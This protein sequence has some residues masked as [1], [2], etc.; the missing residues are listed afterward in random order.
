[1][2]VKN[3]KGEAIVLNE[4]EQK[5]AD[6]NQGIVNAL[7]YEIDITTLTALSKKVIEQKFFEIKPSD[8][9][10]VL[11][12]NGAWSSQIT[13]FTSFE[14]S[15]DFE[16]GNIN[17]GA[18]ESRLASAD[19]GIDSITVKIK[20]WA[21]TIGWSL[22][23]LQMAS[24]SGNWDLIT[25]KE[26]ARKRNWDL[27]IQKI[28]FLG[29]VQD[30]NVKGLL[31]QADVT[32]NLTLITKKISSMSEAEISTFIVGL[33]EAYRANCNRT[34]YPTHFVI[35]ESDF[36]GLGAPSSSTYPIKTKLSLLEDALKVAVGKNVQILPCAYG[37]T[38][39]NSAYINKTRYA[40]YNFDEDSGRL[41]IPV[42]YTATLANSVNNFM[43]QNVGY[44][45][46]TGFKAFRPKEFLYFDF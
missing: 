1:M 15:N 24:K 11:V 3:S 8:Y 13:T 17:T 34:A 22:I 29:S 42:D 40:L 32:S 21:K 41:E 16:A 9:M 23:D 18:S 20:N 39:Y 2:I 45:Q 26:K 46:Y 4:R 44:G 30:A 12:G 35:P 19:T 25:S 6:Y 38:A 31:T 27:G 7:G 43:F 37:D 14:M 33:V 36:L 10:P 5:V 28:A